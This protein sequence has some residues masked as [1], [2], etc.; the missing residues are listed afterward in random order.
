MKKKINTENNHK[1]TAGFYVSFACGCMRACKRLSDEILVVIALWE[2]LFHNS[3][4]RRG[5]K[6]LVVR[7][8]GI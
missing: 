3:T 7:S 5:V 1:K 8:R 2:M 6:G 4:E